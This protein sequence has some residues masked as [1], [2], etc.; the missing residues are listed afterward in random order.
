MQYHWEHEPGLAFVQ[1]Q[2]L[3]PVDMFRMYLVNAAS[4]QPLAD[5]YL[6]FFKTMLR[7][8]RVFGPLP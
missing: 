6:P 7:S 5:T 8:I 2:A 3:I 1:I 4:L